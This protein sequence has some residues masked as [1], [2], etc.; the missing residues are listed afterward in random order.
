VGDGERFVV[1]VSDAVDPL[2]SFVAIL[3]DACGDLLRV[4]AIRDLAC[5]PRFASIERGIL[6]AGERPAPAPFACRGSNAT[7]RSI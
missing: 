1:T 3:E 4:T 5:P 2:P 7:G 6:V